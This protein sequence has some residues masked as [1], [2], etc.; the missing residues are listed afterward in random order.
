MSQKSDIGA[1]PGGARC[2]NRHCRRKAF[3]NFLDLIFCIIAGYL[4]LRGAMRGFFIEIAGIAGVVLGFFLANKYHQELA[5]ELE[6][7]IDAPGWSASIAYFVIFLGCIVLASLVAR[8]LNS[9]V[10]KMAGWLNR[11]AGSLVGVVKG[12]L[13]CLVIFLVL[14]H[15]L[16]D[17]K[18]VT[19]ARSARFMYEAA[20][21]LRPL[22]P[23]IDIP[24]PP[25]PDTL[26][27]D[28]LRDPDAPPPANGGGRNNS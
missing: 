3:M 11:L 1:V 27:E 22:L 2:R 5:P 20:E 9:M 17:S 19:N 16:P 14:S 24:S 23:E 13:I 12:A 8:M 18:L 15:Y 26:R 28:M 21:R 7:F 6:R 10:P 25:L 4:L